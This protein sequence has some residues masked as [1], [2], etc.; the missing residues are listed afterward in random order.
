MGGG[1]SDLMNA[2]WGKK[3]LVISVV[4][5]GEWFQNVHVCVLYTQ[6]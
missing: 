2:L 5:E 3:E 4:S 1:G 6:Y